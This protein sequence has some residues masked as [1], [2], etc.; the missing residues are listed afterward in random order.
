VEKNYPRPDKYAPQSGIV[1]AS[2]AAHP[3]LPV[4]A[5][6]FEHTPTREYLGVHH[7]MIRNGKP[8][9]AAVRGR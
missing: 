9:M 3:R 7:K 6:V 1:G 8:H 2:V 4:S 5:S